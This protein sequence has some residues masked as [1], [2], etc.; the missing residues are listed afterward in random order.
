MELEKT[1][2]D[3][4]KGFGIVLSGGGAMGA[5]EAG[6]VKA[7]KEKGINFKLAAGA[8]VGALNAYLVAADRTEQMVQI[9]ENLNSKK[10]FHISLR[11][12]M[13]GSLLSNAPLEKLLSEEVTEKSTKRIIDGTAKL[14][15]VSSDLRNKCKVIDESFTDYQQIIKSLISSTAIPVA[16]PSRELHLE[17]LVDQI[18]D[19]GLTSN[20]PLED[21]VKKGLCKTFFTTSLF[22]PE[23]ETWYS[24]NIFGIGIRAIETMLTTEYLREINGVREKIK[25]ANALKDI[26]GTKLILKKI[27]KRNKK[28]K[29]LYNDFEVY[30]ENQIIEI[31]PSKKLSLGGPMDF[32]TDRLKKAIEMGY[33]DAKK[34]LEYVEII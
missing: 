5:Y 13:H 14:M 11:N 17:N 22:V 30:A 33:E 29:N 19:G 8:S 26:L 3:S 25:T 34:V 28:T 20:F 21:S 15:I 32:Y 24:H 31:N 6:V 23:E 2:V 18:V 4:E 16:F 1:I 10:V 12:L 27:S 9:W 7:L